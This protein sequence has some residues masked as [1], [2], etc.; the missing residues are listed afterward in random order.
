MASETNLDRRSRSNFLIHLYCDQ[1]LALYNIATSQYFRI[2]LQYS[3]ALYYFSVFYSKKASSGKSRT[4]CTTQLASVVLRCFISYESTKVRKYCR[5]KVLSYIIIEVNLVLVIISGSTY[6]TYLQYVY[7]H[8]SCMHI[9][10]KYEST[11]VDNMEV[12]ILPYLSISGS[13]SSSSCL[14]QE[15][16]ARTQLA[17]YSTTTFVHLYIYKYYESTKVRSLSMTN[18]TYSSPMQISIFKYFSARGENSVAGLNAG[19]GAAP[20]HRATVMTRTRRH[21]GRERGRPCV[22]LDAMKFKRRCQNTNTVIYK[23]VP[24]TSVLP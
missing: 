10:R 2:T 7:M 1:P 24:H 5:T 17:T 11:F 3:A 16:H 15:V 19:I 9:V 6:S 22:P 12:S 4:V 8:E 13:N 23:G 18:K 20:R 21:N 14:F